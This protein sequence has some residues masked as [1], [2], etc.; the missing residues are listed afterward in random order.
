MK[1]N[2]SKSMKRGTDCA[3]QKFPRNKCKQLGHWAV[4]CPQKQQHA[5]NRSAKSAAKKNAN[6]IPAHLM[7]ASRVSS[8][9]ADSW[10]CDSSVTQ[11][12]TLNKHFFVSYT[13]FANPEM[14]VFGKKNLLIWAYDQ[15]VRNVQMF[16]NGMLHDAILKNVWYVPD[17]NVHLFSFKAAT[18]NG[19]SRTL[20]E[21]EVVI[22]GGDG[23]VAASSKL[24]NDL[25]VLAIQVCI[26]QHTADVQLATQ[27]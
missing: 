13:N 17:V 7:R 1:V 9:D 11:H 19:Y 24:V 2:S 23:T 6:A 22:C 18:Q 5:G 21:K 20:N 10:Y 25:Y 4:D 26:P 8:V 12:I 14:I 15:G 27:V 16:N 3:K